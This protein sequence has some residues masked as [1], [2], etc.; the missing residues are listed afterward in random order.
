MFLSI[1]IQRSYLPVISWRVAG[2][3]H[4]AETGD[5][6]SR[7]RVRRKPGFQGVRRVCIPGL[8]PKDSLPHAMLYPPCPVICVCCWERSR[9]ARGCCYGS[10][11]SGLCLGC[12][13]SFDSLET[14]PSSAMEKAGLWLLLL[15]LRC[16]TRSN[17]ASSRCWHTT[18][19][20]GWQLVWQITPQQMRKYCRYYG[21]LIARMC[22]WA[23]LRY[24]LVSPLSCFGYG[25]LYRL[26]QHLFR[27]SRRCPSIQE[28]NIWVSFDVLHL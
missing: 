19:D 6:L 14:S 28:K 24:F 12:R 23:G 20:A 2:F 16:G 22:W 25:F 18:A 17:R 13:A 7:H 15:L 8:V 21:I 11:C 3:K 10:I 9:S 26:W 27:C 4:R 5:A 1:G